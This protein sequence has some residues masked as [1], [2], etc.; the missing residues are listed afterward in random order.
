MNKIY[1]RRDFQRLGLGRK[2]LGEVAERLLAAG[3]TNLV[4]FSIPQNPSGAFYEAL[5]AERLYDQ[6]RVFHGGYVWRD[7][8]KLVKVCKP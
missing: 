5:G 4:L 2:L 7:L 3:K 1:L 6:K 8:E